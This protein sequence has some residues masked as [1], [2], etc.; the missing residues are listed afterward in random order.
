MCLRK[1]SS[2]KINHHTAMTLMMFGGVFSTC[3]HH[4]GAEMKDD[5]HLQSEVDRLSESSIGRA[6]LHTELDGNA[7]NTPVSFVA[8]L[9][10]SLWPCHHF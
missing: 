2:L 3:P 9:C 8:F 10:E 6:V 7:S 5:N 4:R 1:L